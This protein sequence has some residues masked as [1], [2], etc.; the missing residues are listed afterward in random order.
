MHQQLERINNETNSAVAE[1][2]LL[3]SMLL[4]PEAL[5]TGLLFCSPA[6]F[7]VGLHRSAF[8]AMQRLHARGATVSI[9]STMIE[10]YRPAGVPIGKLGAQLVDCTLRVA[11][12]A[13]AEHFARLVGEA[14]D[15]RRLVA[16]ARQVATGRTDGSDE[17]IERLE[18]A[19]R[20]MSAARSGRPER[21]GEILA[22]RYE[23]IAAEAED[24]I[25]VR[26]VLTGLRTLDEQGG[27]RAPEFWILAARPSMG[28]TALALQI[29]VH[30]TVAGERVLFV[31]LEMSKDE[32][33][34]RLFAHESAI[35]VIRL[36]RARIA[37][38]EWTPLRD[39]VARHEPQ[40]LMIVDDGRTSVLELTA[41]AERA[42]LTGPL[43]LIVVDYLQL[44]RPSGRYE[45][46]E[47][48][49]AH[50]S[51][52]LKALAK[53]LQVPV[54]ATAQLN[55]EVEK[56]ENRRPLKSDIRESGALEQDADVIAFLHRPI[57]F[58]EDAEPQEAELI[59]A[60]RRNGPT[61][62]IKMRFDGPRMSFSECE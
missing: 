15:R 9:A 44:V 43:G 27:L 60:K 61:G 18:R 39:T 52:E 53:S 20:E 59:I 42:A 24:R 29:A 45:N 32:L 58:D 31:S 37:P 35:P 19:I 25:V 48:H 16:A 36:R 2:A 22:R 57:V 38:L 14:G 33:A 56:R 17:A 8:E 40:E 47:Q 51:R 5:L 62:T 41:I 3:G 10:S 49:V 6:D 50:V 55:R 11:T 1:Q 54:L 7:L 23:E 34:D 46:R 26:R 12:A 4:A 30:A 28:K 13:N 21:I